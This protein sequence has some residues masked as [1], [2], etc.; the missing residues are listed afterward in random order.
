MNS[1][2]GSAPRFTAIQDIYRRAERH[3]KQV[4]L[5]QAELPFGAINEL[6]YA[7]HHLLKRLVAQESGNSERAE[8]EFQDAEDHCNRAMYEASEAGIG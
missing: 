1:D 6:R 2:K 4:E 5:C 3:I 7:G 8:Q